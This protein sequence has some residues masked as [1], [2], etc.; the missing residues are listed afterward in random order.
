MKTRLS[1]ACLFMLATLLDVSFTCRAATLVVT[2]LADSGPGTLRQSIV[3]AQPGDT[4]TFTNTLSGQGI[5]LTNGQ[6]IIPTNLTIDASNLV[7]GLTIN[8]AGSYSIFEI[9]AGSVV[10]LDSLTLTN[11]FGGEGGAILVDTGGTLTL[12]NSMLTGNSVPTGQGGGGIFN[13]G[14]LTLNNS[15]LSGNS[16]AYGG[17]GGGIFNYGTLTLN[18]TTLS[19]NSAPYGSGGGIDNYFGGVTTINDC[20]L[21]SN[22]TPS[23]VGGGIENSG[24]LTLNN[25]TLAGNSTPS[26]FGGGIFNSGLLTINNS[27]LTGNSAT[28]NSGVGGGIYNVS[29]SPSGTLA[30]TNTIVAGNTDSSGYPNIYGSFSGADNLTN[31]VPL[32]ALL[33]NY[34]GPT[35]TMP[36]LIG[37]PAIDAGDDSVTNFLAADQRGYPRLSGAHVDIGAVEAQ[38]TPANDRPRL[39]NSAWITVGG[40]NSFQFTFTNIA[41][42]DFTALASTNVA[43]PLT[44]WTVLG[45]ITEISPGWYLFTD[46]SVTNYPQRFYEVVSP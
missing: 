23:G 19:G 9:A 6:L 5:I 24:A 43:L 27:T 8:G 22:S 4:I 31:G 34:G 13:N 12:N 29:G 33:G 17:S 32:L 21:S 44:D 16:A 25:S 46:P 7:G 30:L 38:L 37:S 14:T 18:N 39:M 45:N 1:F 15:T 26:G 28:V 35:Q 20:T 3:D 42:A 2:N 36:P 41:D 40:T 11:G 10:T